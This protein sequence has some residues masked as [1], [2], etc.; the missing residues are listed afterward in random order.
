MSGIISLTLKNSKMY[1]RH[2]I[3]VFVLLFYSNNCTQIGASPIIDRNKGFDDDKLEFLDDFTV[4]FKKIVHLAAVNVKGMIISDIE[5]NKNKRNHYNETSDEEIENNNGL[6]NDNDLTEFEES[7]TKDIVN[8][9]VLKYLTD[10]PGICM[11][12]GLKEYMQTWAHPNGSLRISETSRDWAGLTTLFVDKSHKRRNTDESLAREV[13]KECDNMLDNVIAFSAAFNDLEK[14][15]YKTLKRMRK[16]LQY[17]ML[18]GN[19]FRAYIPGGESKKNDLSIAWATFPELSSLKELDISNCKIE[20]ITSAI[21]KNLTNLTSLYISHNK[22]LRV[23]NQA[24]DFVRKLRYLDFSNQNALDFDFKIPIPSV[25]QVVNLLVGVRI[26]QYALANLSKLVYLDLS[27]T[28]LT[29]ATV[30]TFYNLPASIQYISLCYTSLHKVSSTIFRNTKLR[31]LDMS[32]NS[33]AAYSLDD[34]SF[35]AISKSLRVFLYEQGNINNI[36]FMKKLKHLEIVSLSRNNIGNSGLEIF[37]T[38]KNIQILDLSCNHV[39]NW[40]NQIFPNNT[41]LTVLN[42]RSNNINILTSEMMKDFQGLRYLGIGD[43][44]FVCDCVLRDFVDIAIA[45]N[46]KADC[47]SQVFEENHDAIEENIKHLQFPIDL[48]MNFVNASGGFSATI[49]KY[50][51][52]VRR[53]YK[54]LQQQLTNH[55]LFNFRVVSKYFKDLSSNPCPNPSQII[56]YDKINGSSMKF[57]LLDYE[58]IHYWCFNETEKMTFFDLN[59][60]SRSFE[61]VIIQSVRNVTN[62]VVGVSCVVVFLGIAVVVGYVKRWHIHY[63]W[64]SLKSAALLS[65]AAKDKSDSFNNL[66]ESESNLMYDIFISYCQNDRQW[67]LEELMP[68]IEIA[69]DLSICM[70]ERDFEVGVPILDNIITCMDRSRCLMLLISPNFLLSHW[71]QFEMRL[72]QHRMF[73][74][75]KEHVILVFLEDIPKRK[76]PKTLQY[77]MDVKTYIKWPSGSTPNSKLDEKKLFWKRLRRSINNI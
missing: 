61:D 6:G 36:H 66:S 14:A 40:Y 4:T 48:G 8:E 38:Y 10:D 18:K 32:G 15:P 55:K 26:E 73:E 17:L 43:N 71:C 63:Y 21:F 44:D 29:K 7:L 3:L 30:S 52:M 35:A 1:L 25:E 58:D 62:Y 59:C 42:L 28:K 75:S 72:A 56:L 53:S 74:A 45:N 57:Q 13:T 64:S 19:N 27:F 16:K 41:K 76:R 22:I 12:S 77:L 50:A 24:F 33:Y 54:N 67:V 2:T 23:S 39:G 60:Q 46:N 31:G 49:D 11:M 20:F 9:Y 47:L 70:H 51:P 69:G 65:V 37:A 68:N 5:R 34:D